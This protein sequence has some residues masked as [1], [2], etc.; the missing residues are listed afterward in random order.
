M[1]LQALLAEIEKRFIVLVLSIIKY[2]F[3]NRY[4]FRCI[5]IFYKLLQTLVAL[6][7]KTSAHVHALKVLVQNGYSYCFGPY[8]LRNVEKLNRS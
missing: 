5:F 2:N 6:E 3:I 7:Q 4:H 8:R 1:I